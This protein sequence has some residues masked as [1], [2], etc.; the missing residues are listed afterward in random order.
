MFRKQQERAAFE[1]MEKPYCEHLSWWIKSC[2]YSKEI[3]I[4]LKNKMLIFST[5]PFGHTRT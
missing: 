4:V 5:S 1:N 2:I 3:K